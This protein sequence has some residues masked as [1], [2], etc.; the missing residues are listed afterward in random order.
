MGI[1]YLD[2]EYIRF[3][4]GTYL[5]SSDYHGEQNLLLGSSNLHLHYSFSQNQEQIYQLVQVQWKEHLLQVKI[6]L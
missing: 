2:T 6:Q 3:R 4:D 1:P 5:Q